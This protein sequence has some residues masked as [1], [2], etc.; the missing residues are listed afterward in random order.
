MKVIPL[1]G[2]VVIAKVKL[3][4]VTRGKLVL[5][6]GE[7]SSMFFNRSKVIALPPLDPANAIDIE[8][9]RVLRYK[10]YGFKVGDIVV[11]TDLAGTLG[12]PGQ[13][14]DDDGVRREVLLAP[15]DQIIG[16]LEGDEAELDELDKAPSVIKI[17]GGNGEKK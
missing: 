17:H 16:V 1:E 9:G 2:F 10:G 12:V 4:F 6:V 14:T 3:D 7:K 11:T 15:I 8:P 13:I 5:P